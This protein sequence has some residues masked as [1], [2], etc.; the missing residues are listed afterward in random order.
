MTNYTKGRGFE[1]WVKKKLEANGFTVFRSAGSHSAADL[2][3][4]RQLEHFTQTCLIQC[5]TGIKLNKETLAREA[6]IKFSGIPL[7]PTIIDY[8]LFVK[9]NNKEPEFKIVVNKTYRAG[10]YPFLKV[11]EV[12][13]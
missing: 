2:I 8:M 3:A 5:K 11:S 10:E 7:P 13:K 6:L 9:E 1:Y 12:F 4:I